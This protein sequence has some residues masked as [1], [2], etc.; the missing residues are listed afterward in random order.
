MLTGTPGRRGRQPASASQPPPQP[1]LAPSPLPPNHPLQPQ[2]PQPQLQPGPLQQPPQLQPPNLSQPMQQMPDDPPMPI[3]LPEKKLTPTKPLQP[4]LPPELPE[5]PMEPH[6]DRVKAAPSPYCDFCL[7]DAR[8]NKKT[9][10][11]EEL[12]SCSD[13]GRS[14]K[15]ISDNSTNFIDGEKNIIGKKGRKKKLTV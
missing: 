6:A 3:L 14:G 9:G 2:P 11:S 1:Q 8:E 7:G 15:G 5:R 13:C 10:T 4:N 12:V